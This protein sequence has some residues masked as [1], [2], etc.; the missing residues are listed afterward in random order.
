[1]G[2]SNKKNGCL[3]TCGVPLFT[4]NACL[5]AFCGVGASS[6]IVASARMIEKQFGFT[7]TQ[8]TLLVVGGDIAAFVSLIFGYLGGKLHKPRFLGFMVICMGLSF[9]IFTFPY[10]ISAAS[11]NTMTDMISSN[12]TTSTN[13]TKLPDIVCRKSP[14]N[15]SCLTNERLN[16]NTSKQSLN[17]QNMFYVFLIGKLLQGAFSESVYNLPYVYLNENCITSKATFFSGMYMII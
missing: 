10:Y 12:E 6:C 16:N 3:S 9:V 11:D 4:I 5:I 15:S 17:N 13:L 14:D 8:T 1:M 2:K 7:S